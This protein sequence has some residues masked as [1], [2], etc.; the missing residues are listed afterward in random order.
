MVAWEENKPTQ[1]VAQY[2]KFWSHQ[3]MVWF[4]LTVQYVLQLVWHLSYIKMSSYQRVF[5]LGEK[6]KNIMLASHLHERYLSIFTL[7]KSMFVLK[8]WK[9]YCGMSCVS[10]ILFI[11]VVGKKSSTLSFSTCRY[12]CA[13]VTLT[14]EMIYKL[15][16]LLLV[17]WIFLYM[18]YWWLHVFR[19]RLS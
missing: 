17:V 3:N 14:F 4:L 8:N 2:H 18:S 13:G 19:Q 10:L 6:Y 5:T 7:L 11:L 12:F 9:L 16:L 15:Y 1:S